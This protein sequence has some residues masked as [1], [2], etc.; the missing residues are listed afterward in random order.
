VQKS[1]LGPVAFILL[2]LLLVVVLAS[3]LA[4]VGIKRRSVVHPIERMSEKQAELIELNIVATSI[5]DQQTNWTIIVVPR[6][7]SL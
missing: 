7:N 5:N 2:V 4:A 6:T 3:Y 1:G